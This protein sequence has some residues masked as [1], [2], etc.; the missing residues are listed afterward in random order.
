MENEVKKAV[1][2][3][4]D[5]KVTVYGTAQSQALETGKAYTMHPELAK[6]LIAKGAAVKDKAEA[7]KGKK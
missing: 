7:D 3:R 2:V 5:D 4:K 1:K 6:R